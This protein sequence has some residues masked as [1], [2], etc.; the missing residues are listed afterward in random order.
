MKNTSK[1]TA[2]I[3]GLLLPVVASGITTNDDILTAIKANNLSWEY[4][5]NTGNAYALSGLYTSDAIVMPPS[6]ET[7][8]RTDSIRSYWGNIVGNGVINHSIDS[9]DIHIDG[10]T[11]YQAAIW[12]AIQVDDEGFEIPVGGNLVT[13]FERQEDGSWKQKLQ[14][15]N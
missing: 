11:A 2:S 14:S 8:M 5:M 13:I 9:L 1:I 3:L 10:D 6:D 7:L 4:A 15:W 12:S